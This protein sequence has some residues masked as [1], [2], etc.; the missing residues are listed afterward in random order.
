MSIH[1]VVSKLIAVFSPQKLVS[2][3]SELIEEINS[4]K[5]EVRGLKEQNQAYQDEFNRLKGE[6]GKPEF[7]KK[8]PAGNKHLPSNKKELGDSKGREKNKKTSK[9]DRLKITSEEVITDSRIKRKKGYK[10]IIIQDISFST[11]VIKYRLECGYDENNKFVIADLPIQTHGE[12]GVGILAFV[13]TLYYQCRVPMDKIHLVLKNFGIIIGKSVVVKMCH[14]L[15]DKMKKELDVARGTSINKTKV[16]QMDDTGAMVNY[17]NQHTF[18]LSTAHVTVLT[19]INSKSMMSAMY[20]YTGGQR[21]FYLINNDFL[22]FLKK[23]VAEEKYQKYFKKFKRNKPYTEDDFN[24]LMKPFDGEKQFHRAH[25]MRLCAIR[26]WIKSNPRNIPEAVLVTDAAGNFKFMQH[27]HQLCWVHEMRHYRKL[28]ALTD[29]HRELKDQILA[30]LYDFYKKLKLFKQGLISKLDIQSDFAHI[31]Q[32]QTGFKDL[33]EAIINTKK[34]EHGLLTVLRYP[35]VP[36]HNNLCE[37]D[38][39]ENV[40]KRK[41]SGGTKTKLGTYSWDTGL[42]LVHTCRKLKISFYEYLKD[43]YSRAHQLPKLSDLVLAA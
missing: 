14:F 4:L 43:R 25:Q 2:Y 16:V 28:E 18:A 35:F 24:E 34:R 23:L 9:I 21:V 13:K 6:Q 26:E 27:R 32:I 29:V 1:D 41:V 10:D 17:K 7:K 42:S 31:T 33:D 39:R 15:D 11:S 5:K 3:I 40:I 12:F 20:A 8:E 36:L 30:I 19:T 37:Q 38:L 22:F